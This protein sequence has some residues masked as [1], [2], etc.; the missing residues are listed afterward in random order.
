[1]LE[2]LGRTKVIAAVEHLDRAIEAGFHTDS[3]YS[4][5]ERGENRRRIDGAG[6]GVVYAR[7]AGGVE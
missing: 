7:L 3:V 5:P 2:S 6:G 1:M 4:S